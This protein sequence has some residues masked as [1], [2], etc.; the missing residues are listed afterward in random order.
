MFKKTHSSKNGAQ[1]AI[2]MLE[3]VISDA[4]E[5]MINLEKSQKLVISQFYELLEEEHKA[6]AKSAQERLQERAADDRV[7]FIEEFDEPYEV[8]E[9]RRDMAVSH[10][11]GETAQSEEE[12]AKNMETERGKLMEK[13]EKLERQLFEQRRNEEILK[14]DLREIQEI[15]RNELLREW[16]EMQEEQ[17]QQQQ[18]GMM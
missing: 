3:S 18:Q 5:K 12:L 17:K 6:E 14:A 16:E 10:A 15:V 8:V 9:R 7:V 1:V 13:E 4:A 2:E 11:A